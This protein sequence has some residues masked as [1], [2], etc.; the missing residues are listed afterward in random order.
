MRTPV[1]VALAAATALLVSRSAPAFEEVEPNDSIAQANDV[2]GLD[3]VAGTRSAQ[4]VDFFRFTGLIPD[5]FYFASLDNVFLGIG[6]FADDGTL[7]DSVAF[8]G[9]LELE[10][11]V[12]DEFGE[13]IIGVCGHVP[14]DQ[15]V[16]D[17]TSGAAGT[18]LYVLTLPE[19]A[20]RTLSL[21]AL[22]VLARLADRRRRL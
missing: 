1:F 2:V 9:V 12:P 3:D 5:E 15:S 17:C 19:P 11:L 4:D 10:D 13:L 22:A 16:L 21:V 7:L 20:T 6:W 14:P 18:G 8:E